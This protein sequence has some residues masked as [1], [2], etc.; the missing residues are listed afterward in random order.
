MERLKNLIENELNKGISQNK[1][2][3]DIKVSQGTIQKILY[4]YTNIDSLDIPT[5]KKLAAYFRKPMAYFLDP[6]PEDAAGVKISGEGNRPDTRP[7]GSNLDRSKILNEVEQIL[8]SGDY[9]AITA[10]IYNLKGIKKTMQREDMLASNQILTIQA[11][12]ELTEKMA[13]FGA[14]IRA[15][16][17]TLK[18][19]AEAQNEKL[20][21]LLSI[22]LPTEE[23]GAAGEP[24]T[25]RKPRR[26][27]RS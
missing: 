16:N 20:E 15:T 1:L 8:D 9:D 6:A 4:R 10:F 25:K 13:A 24:I 21:R 12:K 5:L 26:V 17:N 18:E 11:I 19:L 14:D 2:S 3:A 7:Q 22:D 27:A 23:P